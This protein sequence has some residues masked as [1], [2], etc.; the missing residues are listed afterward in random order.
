MADAAGRDIDEVVAVFK[1]CG[2]G[3]ARSI[4]EALRVLNEEVAG[5]FPV[6]VGLFEARDVALLGRLGKLLREMFS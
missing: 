4:G 5:L 1:R 3:N 2:D 6:R